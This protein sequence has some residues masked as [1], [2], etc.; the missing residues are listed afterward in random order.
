MFSNFL[1]LGNMLKTEQKIILDSTKQFCNYYLLP[2]VKYDYKNENVDPTIFQEM[3]KVGLFGITNEYGI[4]ESYLTYGLLA[5]EIESIDSGYRSMFSVQNSLVINP[6]HKFGSD[7]LKQKYLPELVSGNLIGCFGLT[8]PDHGSDAGNLRSFA[9]EEDN[10]YL[11]NGSKMWI[12]NAPIADVFVI[13]AKINNVL[14]GFILE[15]DFNGLEVSKI[16]GKLSLRTS[17]TGSIFMENVFVPKEN[18]LDVS[19]F[20]GPFTC[21]ND[22]RMGIAFGVLG[23][24]ETCLD[25]TLDYLNNRVQF[26]DSLS[27][28]QVIQYALGDMLTEYNLSLLSC[29]HIANLRDE[30][31][32]VEH[33][34][35]MI[36][37]I[38]RNSCQKSLNIS[39]KCRDLL[40]GNGISEDYPVFR[41]LTNLETVNT[42]EG[43]ET[44]HA[45]ILG[46]YLTNKSSF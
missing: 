6:I 11:L 24:S 36:S 40:G 5:K 31:P 4:N 9:V 3:G 13:W 17:V 30:N 38:K 2:R 34:P 1:K 33:L 32:N 37:M 22:A 10:G 12:S 27:S 25:T 42:Y 16:E 29:Y 39:R 7:Y 41:H 18:V 8:E 28:K 21:L 45:L 43:T 20:K 44:I 26:G 15:K 35:E 23:A 19:G 46:K 14:K